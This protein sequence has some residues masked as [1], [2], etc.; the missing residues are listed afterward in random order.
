MR[1][2]LSVVI[3]LVVLLTMPTA[4][5]STPDPAPVIHASTSADD[6]PYDSLDQAFNLAEV[7]QA[8]DAGTWNVLI[9]GNRYEFV[10]GP[11]I[12]DVPQESIDGIHWY[13][14]QDYL[15]YPFQAYR[16]EDPGAGAAGH[17]ILTRL[18]MAALIHQD[19]KI[20]DIEPPQDGGAIHKIQEINPQEAILDLATLAQVALQPVA[21]G[22]R[23]FQAELD[24]VANSGS[25]PTCHVSNTYTKVRSIF[26][27][28]FS[29]NI[30]SGVAY[31]CASTACDTAIGLP[32]SPTSLSTMLGEYILAQGPSHYT[33]GGSEI[34]ELNMGITGR[35]FSPGPGAFEL[36]IATLPGH[37]SVTVMRDQSVFDYRSSSYENAINWAHELGHNFNAK[38]H[39]SQTSR[40][41]F[42]DYC[43][44]IEIELTGTCIFPDSRFSYTEY[45][46]KI[47]HEDPIHE[48]P[49]NIASDTYLNSRK[50]TINNCNLG[51]TWSNLDYGTDTT[52][53]S[54]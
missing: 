53:S 5:P 22:D 1:I 38:H 46:R 4:I 11:E 8:L 20:I 47:M 14:P 30:V 33:E 31:L 32:P 25:C 2:Q 17:V 16:I 48:P 36:G 35:S 19:D 28:H 44:I 15:E 9:G 7:R 40:Q 49:N 41:V 13:T 42:E 21:T 6:R 50:T 51:S 34:W 27:N 54:C 26:S 18:G 37:Y 10:A 12:I 29:W 3:G 39:T 45:T 43:T 24:S 52:G 23:R